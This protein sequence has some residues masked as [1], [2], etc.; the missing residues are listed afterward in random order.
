M[1]N[2]ARYS[3]VLS[4]H[5][6]LAEQ[7]PNRDQSFLYLVAL[8]GALVGFYGHENLR[9]DRLAL[10]FGHYLKA[11][12]LLEG[13]P[14]FA[15]V[16]E[17]L[18]ECG[19]EIRTVPTGLIGYVAYPNPTGV[20][21]IYEPFSADIPLTEGSII[22]ERNFEDSHLNALNRLVTTFGQS[23]LTERDRVKGILLDLAPEPRWGVTTLVQAI[24]LG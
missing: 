13:S 24:D 8:R 18:H 7:Y 5:P 15:S 17:V 4:R 23:V 9:R 3:D 1:T 19:H 10:S 14:P 2:H 6:E 16:A 12:P 22:T 11:F 21:D 20:W